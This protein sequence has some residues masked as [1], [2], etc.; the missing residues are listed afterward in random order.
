MNLM[1]GDL[2]VHPLFL[3]NVIRNLWVGEAIAARCI[4][5]Q[6]ATEKQ[7]HE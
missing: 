7:E 5:T 4:E 2:G 6:T 1:L 3:S